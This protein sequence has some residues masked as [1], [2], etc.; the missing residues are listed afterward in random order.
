MSQGSSRAA[1]GFCQEV[2]RKGSA[3]VFLPLSGD[4]H[5]VAEAKEE[6]EVGGI[7]KPRR[8]PGFLRQRLE[9]V[10]GLVFASEHPQ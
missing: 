4:G 3:K 9:N 8:R 1:H 7:K 2:D 6:F 10:V 5:R